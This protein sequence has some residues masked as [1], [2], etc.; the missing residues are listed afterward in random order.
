MVGR[1]FFMIIGVVFSITP[2]FVYWLAATL[3]MNGDPT[4]PTAGQIVAF[5][6]LQSRLFFPLGSLLNVQV[7]IQGS[8]ALFDRIF[9]YLDLDPEIVDAPD[10]VGPRPGDRPGQ[11]PPPRGVVPLPERGRPGG[12]CPGRRGGRARGDGRLA[13]A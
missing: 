9:E 1:W 3:A 7:E 6:T 11:G 4:A 12:R 13:R 10:A 5:T 2:A 8:L